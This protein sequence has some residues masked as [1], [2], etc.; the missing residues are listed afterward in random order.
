L[1]HSIVRDDSHVTMLQILGL[2]RAK[3]GVGQEQHVVMK[4]FRVPAVVLMKGVFRV[5]PRRLIK[6]FVR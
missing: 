3:A 6:L 5:F 2:V 1:A 4:L